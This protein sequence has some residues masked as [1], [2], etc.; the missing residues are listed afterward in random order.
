MQQRRPQTFMMR[1]VLLNGQT[2]L[3]HNVST[4]YRT[5][6]YCRTPQDPRS[7]WDFH[8]TLELIVDTHTTRSE[9]CAGVFSS[10]ILVLLFVH[11]GID[12]A[13]IDHSCLAL[14]LVALLNR[15]S[16]VFNTHTRWYGTLLS[17]VAN[18]PTHRSR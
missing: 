4:P 17:E 12:I 14:S 2:E 18:D 11:F 5:F 3:A 1:C 7:T 6:A 16:L 10:R 9:C 15:Q 13:Y 8:V